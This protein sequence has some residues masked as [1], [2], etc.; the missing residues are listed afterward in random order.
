MFL[1]IWRLWGVDTR[2]RKILF[3]Q[4]SFHREPASKDCGEFSLKSYL[5]LRD[6]FSC[7]DIVIISKLWNIETSSCE[8]GGESVSKICIE[9]PARSEEKCDC[10]RKD[11]TAIAQNSLI[12]V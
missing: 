6:W 2:R 11:Y 7:L 8:I 4:G 12:A 9:F 1:I 5:V 3:C 10:F